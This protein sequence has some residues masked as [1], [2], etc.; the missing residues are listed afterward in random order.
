MEEEYFWKIISLIKNDNKI[1]FKSTQE[2][3]NSMY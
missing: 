3:I 1:N 2:L